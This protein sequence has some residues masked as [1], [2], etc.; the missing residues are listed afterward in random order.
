M[1]ID[2]DVW[3]RYTAR[4]QKINTEAARLISEWVD[5]HGLDDVQALIDYAYGVAT[6]YGEAAGAWAAEMYDAISELSDEYTEPAEIAYTPTYGTVRKTIY[7]V[8]K[9]S[10]NV[11]MISSAVGRLVK[12][13]GADTMLRNASR[14]GAEYAWIAQGDTCP[15]CLM[16]AAEG[17]QRA[18]KRGME[19]HSEHIH[20]N[21]D[22][23]YCI[24]FDSDTKVGGY[25]PDR[26]ARMFD[27][28]DGDTEEE[29]LNSM[30]RE[31]YAENRDEINAQKRDA[32]QKRQELNSSEAEEIDV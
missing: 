23:E 24:R 6:K 29:K 31:A 9:T 32:Y 10:L 14:D 28:A 21:C 30:R 11:E 27:A 17:W 22:C 13:T 3:R 1:T 15:Y 2:R 5:A 26:Y 12:K 20:G 8:M 18:S 16:I 7:G 25:D 19:S 4:L